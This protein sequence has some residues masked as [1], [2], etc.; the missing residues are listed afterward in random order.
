MLKYISKA[1]EL[2][3]IIEYMNQNP[4]KYNVRSEFQKKHNNLRC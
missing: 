1:V 2:Y 3:Y 4:S